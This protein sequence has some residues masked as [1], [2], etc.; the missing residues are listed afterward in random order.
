MKQT[1]ADTDRT[2]DYKTDARLLDLKNSAHYLSVSYWLVREL[3]LKGEIAHLRAGKKILI[4]IQDLD[5]WIE[6]NKEFAA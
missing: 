5:S 3:V 6:K 1:K 4:D 2:T